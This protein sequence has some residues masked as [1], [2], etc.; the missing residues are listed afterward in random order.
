MLYDF[1]IF[2]QAFHDFVRSLAISS[3]LLMIFT[4]VASC[5][6]ILSDVG[7]LCQIL[8]DVGDICRGKYKIWTFIDVVM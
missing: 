2:C 8:G 5:L 4:Y 7:R 6:V 1:Y 3:Y